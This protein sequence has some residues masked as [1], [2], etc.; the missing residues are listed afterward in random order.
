MV[1][2]LCLY[3]GSVGKFWRF[4]IT[5]MRHSPIDNNLCAPRFCLDVFVFAYAKVSACVIRFSVP[6][7]LLIY[8]YRNVSQVFYPVVI[9]NTVDMVSLLLRPF[10]VNVQP[11]KPMC[12][13]SFPFYIN[14][15]VP[16][17]NGA[18]H[19]S[20]YCCSS[21]KK[22]SKNSSRCFVVKDFFQTRLRKH[23]GSLIKVSGGCGQ[24]LIRLFSLAAIPQRSLSHSV[25]P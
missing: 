7:V 11:C 10:S 14:P 9:A 22:I 25:M 17:P 6:D 12:R 4:K 2:A 3:I 21:G 16:I 8:V 20:N 23:F 15:S 19:R 18:G 24:E 13:E 1:N 5:K